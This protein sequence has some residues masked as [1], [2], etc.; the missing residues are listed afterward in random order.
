MKTFD[1]TASSDLDDLISAAAAE[2]TQGV[3]SSGF[4]ARVMANLDVAPRGRWPRAASGIAAAAA[5]ALLAFWLPRFGHLERPTVP[6]TRADAPELANNP[7]TA[8]ALPLQVPA[9][10][11]RQPASHP[12]AISADEAAWLSRAVAPL[13]VSPAIALDPIQPEGSTI[14]PISIQPLVPEPID[15]TPLVGSSSAGGGR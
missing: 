13:S 15:V 2:M 7:P 1:S 4:S 3:P 8:P 9:G 14:A 10:S 5:V 11:R 6:D 12:P